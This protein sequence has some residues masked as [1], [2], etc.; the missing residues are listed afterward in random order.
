MANE[1]FDRIV[2]FFSFDVVINFNCEIRNDTD[3]LL[4]WTRRW[5]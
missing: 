5:K 4:F 3:A 2:G 1:I